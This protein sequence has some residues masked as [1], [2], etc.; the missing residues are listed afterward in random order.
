MERP[1]LEHV[2]DDFPCME[3]GHK[4]KYHYMID[5]GTWECSICGEIYRLGREKTSK[6]YN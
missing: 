3:C 4:S 1:L 2:F 5:Y 6:N